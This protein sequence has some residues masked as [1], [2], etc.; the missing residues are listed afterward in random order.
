M[1][2][3]EPMKSLAVST[4]LLFF[5]FAAA[6]DAG[7]SDRH[8]AQH[9]AASPTDVSAQTRRRVRTRVYVYPSRQPAAWDYPRPGDVSWPGPGAVRDC[10]SWLEPEYRP[11]GTVIV[12]RMRCAWVRG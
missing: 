7:A 10:V 12:P 1:G 3:L 4:L 8:A 9:A 11:S 5:A 2:E 6:P